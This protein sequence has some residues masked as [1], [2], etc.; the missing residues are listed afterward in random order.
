MAYYP[1]TIK[2]KDAFNRVTRKMFE[3]SAATFVDA[4]AIALDLIA[5]M[6][7]IIGGQIVEATLGDYL[8]LVGLKGAPDAG[9][10]VDDGITFSAWLDKMPPEKAALKVPT[11]NTTASWIDANGDVDL[12]DLDIK[13]FTDDF[14]GVIYVPI[15]DREHV[16][17]FIS[18]RLD[19]K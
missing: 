13:A 1:L 3:L 10:S 9:C 17:E 6:D 2:I 4:S 14:D 5:D 18:A 16:E 7:A 8:S 11:V 12:A 19:S 15:S